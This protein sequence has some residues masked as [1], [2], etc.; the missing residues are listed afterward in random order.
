M[1]ETRTNPTRFPAA[2]PIPFAL[3]L[4]FSSSGFVQKY[5]G[6]AGLAAYA[7]GVIVVLLVVAKFRQ[8]TDRF[9]RP[10]FREITI[11]VFAALAAVC[12]GLHHIE[13]DRGPGRSSDRDEALEIAVTRLLGGENPYYPQNETA[14]PLSLLPGAVILAVPFA[15]VGFVGVQN[16]LW[17]G[18]FICVA[19]A[20]FRDPV[21]ALL[22]ICLSLGL[23]PSAQYEFISWGDIIANGAY[24]ACF[25]AFAWNR[26]ND[27]KSSSA[28][29]FAAALLLALGL[30][31]RANFILLLPLFGAALW[32]SRGFPRAVS[33]VFLVAAC[34][35]LIVL[36]FYFRDP[37][38]FTPLLSRNKLNLPGHAFP[39]AGKAIL[40]ITG[41]SAIGASA[42]LR[43]HDSGG[44]P[45]ALFRCAAL[46]TLVPM[47]CMVLLSSVLS[48]SPDFRFM[49]DRFGLMF[50]FLA[51]LGWGATLGKIPRPRNPTITP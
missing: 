3:L 35:L 13:D 32:R 47:L 40:A 31:S 23:S 7:L 46:V 8:S 27:E 28:L 41:C 51:L 16:L 30:A 33:A 34:Y 36:P 22:L 5:L 43:W 50:I 20:R 19:A 10:R 45:H 24:V 48:R 44:K 6:T 18:V 38:A 29:R 2:T 49:H 25:L 9:L 14:G 17:L 4:A 42:W 1:T 39:W 21:L 37:A 26:W 11:A 15:A 12:F